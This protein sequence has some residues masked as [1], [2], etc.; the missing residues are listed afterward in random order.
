M[1]PRIVDLRPQLRAF[2]VEALTKD[3]IPIKVVTFVP[4]R[5]ETGNQ[6]VELGRGFPFRQSAVYQALA[7]EVV[8]RKPD[9][10][11]RES[12]KKYEWNGGPEDGLVP[13]LATPI[14]QDV[15]SRYNIDEL[16]APFDPEKDPRVEIAGEIRERI[17]E[18]IRERGLEMIGGG[19]SNLIPQDEKIIKRRIENWQTRWAGQILIQLS[20]SQAYRMNQLGL[21]RAKSEIEV[22]RRFGQIIKSSVKDDLNR[23]LI[24][25]LI[26]SIREV[27]GEKEDQRRLPSKEIEETLKRLRGEC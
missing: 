23:T 8:E 25:G 16:C 27:V 9:K 22:V 11:D 14:V 1:E 4:Y 20:H 13:L 6:T 21:A 26:D 3:G 7:S 24:L 15:I 10:A 19:I 17:K 12:G 5:I 2:P 18:T